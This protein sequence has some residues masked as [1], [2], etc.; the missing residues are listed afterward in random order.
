MTDALRCP[1]CTTAAFRLGLGRV[2]ARGF[3]VGVER[4]LAALGGEA[5]GGDGRIWMGYG[6]DMDPK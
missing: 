1:T 5:L 3:R 2:C 4:A 6:W